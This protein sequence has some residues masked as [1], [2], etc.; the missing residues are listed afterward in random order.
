MELIATFF[1]AAL[2]AL[3]LE[4]A[5][6]ARALG[7][8]RESMFIRS[9]GRCVLFGGM[10]TYMALLS[11]C[12]VALV[13]FLLAGSPHIL[14]IRPLGYL[15]GVIIIYL[16]SGKIF[17]HTFSE[18]VFAKIKEVMPTATLNSALFGAFYISA[19]QNFGTVQ[20]LGYALGAGVGYTLALLIIYY[21]RKRLAISPVPRSFKGMPIL[22]IYLGLISLALY[23]L[24]GHA[25][26]T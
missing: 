15:A 14:I 2:T 1:G 17:R 22:L 10:L 24:I 21:A 3:A 23:G 4:N 7:L 11:S 9:P 8:G 20:T 12:L 13:N 25:L 26:P 16:M 5:V 6:I 19:S 18:P